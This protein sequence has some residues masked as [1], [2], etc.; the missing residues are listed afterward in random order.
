MQIGEV[1]FG[2]VGC[3]LYDA[4]LRHLDRVHCRADG[5][6]HSGISGK[7]IEP[8]E[9]KWAVLACLA[10]P[11]AI[12]AGSGTAAMVPEVMDSLNNGGAHGFSGDALRIHF[13]WRK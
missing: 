9:M 2:G 10:T 8:R 6:S 7:K 1:I 12:L 4:G 5:R 11:I 13:R 3:G